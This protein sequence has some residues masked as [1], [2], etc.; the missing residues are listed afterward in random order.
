MYRRCERWLLWDAGRL[1][2][3]VRDD[4]SRN[5]SRRSVEHTERA[6]VQ[7]AESVSPQPVPS[8]LP[9]GYTEGYAVLCFMPGTMVAPGGVNDAAYALHSA[10]QHPFPSATS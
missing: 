8:A 1:P 3:K 5:H 2:K 9:Q 4:S 10:L 6:A 7:L